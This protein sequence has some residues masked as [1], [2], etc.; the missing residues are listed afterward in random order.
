MLLL[1]WNGSTVVGSVPATATAA[2]LAP[3][4]TFPMSVTA[5]AATA[6]AA[7]LAP[8]LSI[9]SAGGGHPQNRGARRLM[10][11]QVGK[12]W[13]EEVRRLN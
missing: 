4:I 7:G 9:V 2:G 1:F 6:T 10:V 11:Y 12:N 5:T 13:Y 3:A 8:E